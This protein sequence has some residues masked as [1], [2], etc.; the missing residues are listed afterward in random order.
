MNRPGAGQLL[1]VPKAFAPH[2]VVKRGTIAR[3]LDCA[4][5]IMAA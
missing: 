4:K 5:N 3:P 2:A 1:G